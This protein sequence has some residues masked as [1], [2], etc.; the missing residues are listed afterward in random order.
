[1]SLQNGLVSSFLLPFVLLSAPASVTEAALVYEFIQTETNDLIATIE[2]TSLPAQHTEIG[3]LTFEP[4]GTTLFGYSGLYRGAFDRTGTTVGGQ[5][6]FV[7]D[8]GSGGLAMT[9]R[10]TGRVWFADQVNPQDSPLHTALG[11][12]ELFL[13]FG[14]G[15]SS[16]DEIL[17]V[18]EI[19][20]VDPRISVQGNWIAV[21]AVP[22]PSSTVF[23]IASA[24]VALIV[25]RRRGRRKST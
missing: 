2:L 11:T 19:P 23:L 5:F 9:P 8:D 13:Y 25:S 12:K 22:E 15:Q 14:E 16:S 24:A 20:F 18:P 6:P 4:T 17:L 3:S 7:G 10:G 1:M 21:T